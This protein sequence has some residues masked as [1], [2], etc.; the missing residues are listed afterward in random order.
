MDSRRILKKQ[1][2]LAKKREYLSQYFL[3][4][5][6]TKEKSHLT[7]QA[8]IVELKKEKR[9]HPDPLLADLKQQ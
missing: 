2:R 6:L 1:A 4:R 8:V 5:N 9:Y 7:S 3:R